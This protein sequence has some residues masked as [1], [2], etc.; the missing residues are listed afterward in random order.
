MDNKN[1]NDNVNLTTSNE[2]SYIT[3]GDLIK[4]ILKNWILL[5]VITLVITVIG[6]IY[7]FGIAKE[8]YKGSST[9]IVEVKSDSN[10][11]DSNVNISYSNT[12]VNTVASVLKDTNTIKKAVDKYN[13]ENKNDKNYQEITYSQFADELSTTVTT[14]NNYLTFVIKD[15]NKDRI[16]ALSTYVM[17]Y[18]VSLSND[19]DESTKED[20]VCEI[21][22]LSVPDSLSDIKYNS[23]NKP[24]Y[25]IISL[26][27]GLVVGC[28]VVFIKEFASS[29]FQSKEEV[30]ALGLPIIGIKVD[31]KEKDKKFEDDDLVKPSIRAFEPYNRILTNIKF[32]NVDNPYKTIMITSTQM[33][34]FKST[35]L[36]NLAYAAVNNGKKTIIID[37]D[38][39]RARVHKIFEITKENGVSDYLVGNTEL[40]DVIKHTSVGVDVI[41][42]GNGVDNPVLVLESQKLRDLVATLKETYDYVFIDTPP[43]LACSDALEIAKFA[44]GIIY[45]VALQGANKKDI[46]DSLDSLKHN[47]SNLIG[48]NITN[49]KMTKKEGYYYYQ[50]GYGESSK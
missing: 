29:K 44:D 17:D 25:L 47:D 32:A 16:I 50:Y 23:P 7:T 43:L 14:N 42:G 13:S 45:N 24:L 4:S 8:T 15:T 35:V 19:Y 21:K 38:L 6:A 22:K 5:C 27:A 36:S 10:N 9:L 26:L 28:A 12:Y 46:K 41:T 39:R 2:Q 30:E 40:N 18:I 1:V 3:L 20:L 34:E 49:V 31:S 33:G 11:Q 37:L 48:I